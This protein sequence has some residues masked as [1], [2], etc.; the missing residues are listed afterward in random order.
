[1]SQT[2]TSTEDRRDDV[3]QEDNR[4]K[5]YTEWLEEQN[6]DDIGERWWRPG[7]DTGY[8]WTIPDGRKYSPIDRSRFGPVFHAGGSAPNADTGDFA[9][10]YITSAIIAAGLS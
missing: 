4:G 2:Y 5:T 3:N 6:W 7:A 10:H 9:R 1:M 8:D